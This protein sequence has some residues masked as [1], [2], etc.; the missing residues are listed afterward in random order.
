M[1]TQELIEEMQ[2]EQWELPQRNYII[3]CPN[4]KFWDIRCLFKKLDVSIIFESGNEFIV[5]VDRMLADDIYN[6]G[7]AVA[8]V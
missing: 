6:A 8:E 5:K 7:Y 4:G 1:T 2:D 3:Y